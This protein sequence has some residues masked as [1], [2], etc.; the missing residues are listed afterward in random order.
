[1]WKQAELICCQMLLS[2]PEAFQ[3]WPQK[4]DLTKALSE[5]SPSLLTH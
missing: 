5:E 3:H 4:N 2:G 1:M